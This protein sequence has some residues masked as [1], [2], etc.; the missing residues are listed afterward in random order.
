MGRSAEGSTK[1][2]DVTCEKETQADGRKGIERCHIIM[3]MPGMRWSQED[4]PSL[5]TLHDQ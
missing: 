3:Q 4:A 5:P 1:E 2:K